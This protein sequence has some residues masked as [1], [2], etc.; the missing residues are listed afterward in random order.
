MCINFSRGWRV[1]SKAWRRMQY[2]LTVYLMADYRGSRFDGYCWA[3]AAVLVLGL[4]VI[5]L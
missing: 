4:G 1:I 2:R 3:M 5:Y